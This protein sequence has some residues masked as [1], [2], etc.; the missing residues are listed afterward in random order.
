MT[1]AELVPYLDPIQ[2]TIGELPFYSS[3]I[4]EIITLK[5][6]FGNTCKFTGDIKPGQRKCPLI[7]LR[8]GAFY[9]V[10]SVNE[11]FKLLWRTNRKYVLTATAF[12][13]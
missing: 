7:A 4:T 10:Q 9:W 6:L 5:T 11:C 13:R 3:Q 2:G 8:L 12:Q 1:A